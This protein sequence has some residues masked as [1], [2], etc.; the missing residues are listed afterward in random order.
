M[1]YKTIQ[2]DTW[3][4]IAKKIYGKEIYADFL[5]T[6]NFKELDKFVFPEGI[7]LN[8]PDLPEEKD[9]DLPPWRD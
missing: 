8:T 7:I 6:N 9:D 1:A 5:M 2:G 4:I 3:D